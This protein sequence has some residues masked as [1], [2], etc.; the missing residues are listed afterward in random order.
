MRFRCFAALLLLVVC[1][2]LWGQ[3]DPAPE[4]VKDPTAL[5]ALVQRHYDFSDPSLKPWHLKA[6]YQVYDENGKNPQRGTY[7]Y[8]WASPKV[9]RST[10]T[11]GGDSRSEWHTADGKTYVETSGKDLYVMEIGVPEDLFAP[12]PKSADYGGGNFRRERQMIR[13]GAVSL[14]CVEIINEDPRPNSVEASYCFDPKVPVLV[15]SGS[16]NRGRISYSN[17]AQ[18]QQRGLARTFKEGVDGRLL[19]T[20]TV[21]QVSGLAFNDPALTPTSD[22]HDGAADPECMPELR[23]RTTRT[24]GKMPTYPEDA[25]HAHLTGTVILEVAIGKNGKVNDVRVL[26]SPGILLE[27]AAKKAVSTWEYT[28]H[29]DNGKPTEVRAMIGVSYQ[30]T[31]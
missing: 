27:E 25:R 26:S 8:W 22:A 31:P 21:E 5:L 3:A 4:T 19:L 17:F 11:R 14:P 20:V 13:I 18:V 12:L 15:L 30:M 16:L 9:Y 23:F 24:G 7:E 6:T 28:P 1:A 29:L 10:W 2:S